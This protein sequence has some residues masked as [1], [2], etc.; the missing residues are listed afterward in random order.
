MKYLILPDVHNRFEKVEKI[1]KSVKP[2]KTI[3]LGDYFDDFGDDPQII[4]EVADWFHHSVNQK[5]RIHICGNH[6]LHYWFKN[7][8]AMRCSGYEQFKS[9]AINDFVTK[10]DWEKLKFFY[11][12]DGRWLLSHGGLHPSW[13]DSNNFQAD[14][15]IESSLDKIKPFLEA[16]SIEAKKLFYANRMHWFAMPGFSR[17]RSPYYGGITWCDWTKEFHPIRGIHQIVGHTPDYKLT[18]N[19]IEEGGSK[20]DTLPL[21]GV[22]NPTLTDKNSYNLCLDSHPGS[23]YYAIYKDGKLTVHKADDIK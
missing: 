11:I 21:E 10:Q 6:D 14:S 9:I 19:V 8:D 22:S 1:I 3:F 12:L 4:A 7:N 23:Q 16:S 5:D 15:I 17:S 20:F 2:D 18:W 13:I